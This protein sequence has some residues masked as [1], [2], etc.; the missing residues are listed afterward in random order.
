[1]PTARECRSR[2]WNAGWRR[3]WR[4]RQVDLGVRRF[5]AALFAF[6]SW[7]SRRCRTDVFFDPT[8]ENGK[9]RKKERKKERK[10]AASRRHSQ[11]RKIRSRWSNTR[12]GDPSRAFAGARGSRVAAARTG[13]A[14]R[15]EALPAVAELCWGERPW[16]AR[17]AFG[18]RRCDLRGARSR[19]VSSSNSCV[20]RSS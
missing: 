10:K 15:S 12:H 18:S 16:K 11:C 14:S 17:Q 19:R 1:M 4:M 9:R 20:A 5:D 8:K 2:R 7:L 6:L 13:P 3:I